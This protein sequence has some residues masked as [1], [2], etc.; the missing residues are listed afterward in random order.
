MEQNLVKSND[1]RRSLNAIYYG[2]SKNVFFHHCICYIHKLY[3]L[4]IG[5]GI[6]KWMFVYL[7]ICIH[8]FVHKIN[9]YCQ[10]IN[11]MFDFCLFLEFLFVSWNAWRT[12][13]SRHSL[14]TSPAA[15]RDSPRSTLLEEAMTSSRGRYI[16]I[17]QSGAVDSLCPQVPYRDHC[18][19]SS[20]LPL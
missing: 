10:R 7:I 9:Y 18:L 19:T 15:F 20:Y 6:H 5:I 14:P 12:L 1:W 3:I 2:V 13:A 8:S 16:N 4:Y 17:C 11:A